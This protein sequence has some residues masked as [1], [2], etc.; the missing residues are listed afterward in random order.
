VKGAGAMA[1][2]QALD[3]RSFLNAVSGELLSWRELD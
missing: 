1:P 3:A 2:A